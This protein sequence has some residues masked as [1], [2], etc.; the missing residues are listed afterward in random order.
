MDRVVA[1]ERGRDGRNGIA[2][3]DLVVDEAQS[4][5]GI[6]RL[7]LEGDEHSVLTDEA[8]IVGFDFVVIATRAPMA[9]R[10]KTRDVKRLLSTMCVRFDRFPARRISCPVKLC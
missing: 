5:V 10:G 3:E 8:A 2:V 6:A 1:H 7:I 4:L 9:W